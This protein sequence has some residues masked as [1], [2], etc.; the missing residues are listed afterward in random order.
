V[1]ES[2]IITPHDIAPSR[3]QLFSKKFIEK[4]GA[5]AAILVLNFTLFLLFGTL[6]I[7]HVIAASV[8]VPM[9]FVKLKAEP[10]K[11][12]RPP[13]HGGEGAKSILDP[14][15]AVVPPTSIL[16]AITST[17]TTATFSMQAVDLPVTTNL[18]SF[19]Q[20]AGAGIGEGTSG[21]GLPHSNPFGDSPAS[22]VPGLI[23]ELYDLK[24]TPD[25]TPTPIQKSAG[26]GLKVLRNYVK[27]WDQGILDHYYKSPSQ[28]EATQIFIP[29][30]H[31]EEATKAFNVADKVEAKRWVIHY[32]GTMVPLKSGRFR[33]L[34]FG[35]DFLVVRLGEANVLDGSYPGEKLDESANDNEEGMPGPHGHPLFSGKWFDAV[36]GQ[37]TPIDILIGEGPGGFSGFVLLI[38]E[39]G[40]KSRKGDY[41][42]FQMAPAPITVTT[43]MPSSFTGKTM[44]FGAQ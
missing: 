23:G 40:D 9:T 26:E 15:V 36:S 25:G 13:A 18:P 44:V 3:R 43:D 37:A 14:T 31:S 1:S 29:T 28:L 35:D 5:F 11:P 12:P 38:E 22:G 17:S 10:P 7:W 33:F 39:H 4:F 34:G 27:G 6:V 32:H 16:S 2:A 8:E 21:G 41:P 19:S 20:P 42:V 30:R 24:Q